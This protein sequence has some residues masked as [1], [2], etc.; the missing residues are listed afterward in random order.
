MN[1]RFLVM[2]IIFNVYNNVPVFC[3][4]SKDR[5]NCA[6]ILVNFENVYHKTIINAFSKNMKAALIF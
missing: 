6:K 4:C 5:M 1:L 3:F 2:P